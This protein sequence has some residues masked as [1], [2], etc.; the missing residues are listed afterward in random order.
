[1]SVSDSKKAS[2]TDWDR[3]TDPSDDGIDYSDIPPL[4]DE[5]FEQAEWRL[6]KGH[7][8]P[9]T[10]KLDA[11]VL[12]WFQAQGE[13]YLERMRVVLKAYKEAHVKA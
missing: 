2:L 10:L 11:D 3:L 9:V 4:D 13:G 7:L 6:P 8:R 12:G 1:M 5:F